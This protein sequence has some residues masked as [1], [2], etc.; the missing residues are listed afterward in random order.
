MR[1][2]YSVV[3][4]VFESAAVVAKTVDDCRRFFQARGVAHEILLINDGSRDES[5][6]VLRVLAE[7]DPNVAAVDLLRNYGQHTAVLCGLQFSRGDW[8]VTLDDDGQNPAEEIAHL[9]TL[10][11]RGHDAV[12]GVPRV[13]AHAVARRLGSRL[14]NALNRRIFGKPKDLVLT[15]FRLIERRVVDRI[16]A[17]RTLYPYINGLTVLYARHPANVAVEH[18]PRTLG[19]SNY[20]P[21]KI[22]EVMARIVFNYSSYPLRVVTVVGFMA[23]AVSFLLGA[24]FL[25][26]GLF[27]EP[28]V[29]GWASVAVMLA[30][31]NGLL[32]LLLG[33]IGEYVLRVLQQVSH[34][35]SYEIAEVL[36]GEA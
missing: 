6:E 13:K 33:M 29:P 27:L 9:I 30:F 12:F 2:L 4:P 22:A 24:Y 11:E 5:W 7:A 15:N 32:L 17:H 16:L 28:S 34:D 25:G 20:G 23:A 36:R 3:I 19:R 18:R 21:L 14:I 8:V 35:R 26:R 31:F 10:A 1:P